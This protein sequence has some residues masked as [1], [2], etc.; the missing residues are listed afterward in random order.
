MAD[1]QIPITAIVT[2]ASVHDSQL[3]IPMAEI[4]AQRVTSLYDLMDTGYLGAEIAEHS[5]ML[6]HVP[7]VAPRRNAP[8]TKHQIVKGKQPPQLSWAQQERYKERTMVER[9]HSRLKD[10]FGCRQ[11]FVRGHAKVTAH[12]MFAVLVLTADQILRLVRP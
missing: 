2:S 5:R 10:E 1:G 12:L 6:G 7:I 4:T 8:K 11:I 9:V 3:A